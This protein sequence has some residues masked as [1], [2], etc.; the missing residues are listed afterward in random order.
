VLVVSRREFWTILN[1]LAARLIGLLVFKA[2]MRGNNP[3]AGAVT[4]FDPEAQ[5][6]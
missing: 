4:T 3:L 5:L 2:P 6:L 1:F